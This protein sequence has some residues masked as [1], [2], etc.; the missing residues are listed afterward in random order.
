MRNP[1]ISFAALQTQ[2]TCKNVLTLLLF[3][4]PVFTTPIVGA[5]QNPVFNITDYG[6]SGDYIDENHNSTDN[7]GPYNAAVAA[8]DAAG[9][10]GTIV[11]PA[12]QFRFSGDAVLGFGKNLLGFGRYGTG[13]V[14]AS[15]SLV[16][17]TDPEHP[18]NGKLSGVSISRTGDFSAI[19][20]GSVGIKALYYQYPVI[21]DCYIATHDIGIKTGNLSLGLK[22]ANTVVYDIKTTSLWLHDAI[23]TTLFD[24]DFGK[25]ANIH[26]PSNAFIVFSGMT[27]TVN[28][29]LG[30]PLGI[31]DTPPHAVFKW[32]NYTSTNGIFQFSHLNIEHVNTIFW[33]DANT[34]LINHL[35]V[36]NSRLT[37]FG[38]F[39]EFDD[40]TKMTALDISHNP[41]IS[42]YTA[43]TLKAPS[44]SS[45]SNNVVSG[46]LVFDGGD[47]GTGDLNVSNNT[48]QTDTMLT[49]NWKALVSV[50]NRFR[51]DTNVEINYILT[52]TG[53]VTSVGNTKQVGTQP[54]TILPGNILQPAWVEVT[55]LSSWINF[56]ATSEQVAGYRKNTTGDVE[57]RGLL[58][59]GTNAGTPLLTVLPAGYR[60]NKREFFAVAAPGGAIIR[61]EPDG[62]VRLD[63]PGSNNSFLSLSGIHFTASP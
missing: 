56:N 51:Y 41:Q 61:V 53:N 9:G 15:G 58:K 10:Y 32:E 11:F 22:I 5:H 45:F 28:Y 25:D 4:F 26:D 55:P 20:A 13:L 1:F 36:T 8:I 38:K 40:A 3:A 27:D 31:S 29:D 44:T 47:T 42:F 14:F 23:Q 63:T 59:N 57:L 49:G 18:F 24:V 7:L 33:S 46:W 6:G 43:T 35:Q 34:P 37:S 50:G 19:P 2:R 30:N 12:G 54:P 16:F 48:F 62:G 21:E 17:G 52:A 60:P 39:A